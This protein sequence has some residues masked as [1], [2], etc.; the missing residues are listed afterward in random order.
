NERDVVHARR[1]V[2]Q[3][4]RNLQARL[5]VLGKFVGRGKNSGVFSGGNHVCCQIP[6]RYF[7]GIF[8]KQRLWIKKVYLAGA[9]IHEQLDYSLSFGPKMRRFWFEIV[10]AGFF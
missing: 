10:A 3:K 2:W 6:A 5:P 9:A 8:A 4:L 1:R 7:A